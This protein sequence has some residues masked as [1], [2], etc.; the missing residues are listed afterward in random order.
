MKTY[1]ESLAKVRGMV[2]EKLSNERKL[3]GLATCLVEARSDSGQ[4]AELEKEIGYLKWRN[5]VLSGSIR[6]AVS[7]LFF[8]YEEDSH[9]IAG[10]IDS[11][12]ML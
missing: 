2:E 9:D 1:E 4:V 5:Q 12:T 3:V 10:D 11:F 7:M 8:I 6:G